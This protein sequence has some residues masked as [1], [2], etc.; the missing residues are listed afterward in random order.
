MTTEFSAP[1]PMQRAATPTAPRFRLHRA[2]IRNVWQY[3]E[4]E[5]AFGD[6]RLLLRGKNGAG[7]SKA[8]EML[9][10][11]LLDGDAR[12][13]DATGTGRTTLVWLML[14]GFEQTNRLGYLWVEFHLSAADGSDRYLTIGAAI[15]ASK[16]TK[17]AVPVFFVTPLRVGEDLHLV[18]AG[19]PLPVDKLKESI[20]AA[21][22]TERAVEHRARVARELFGITDTTRF[23]N[24]T[25]LLHRLRRPTVGDRIE[26][27]GLVSLLSETLPG[28][29]EEVVEKVARNLHDLDAVRDE[30][31]RLE[32]TD[33]A[34][35]A[36]LTGYRGYLTGVLRRASAG[37]SHELDVLTEWRRR[38]G[39][40]AKKTSDLR[41][42]EAEAD[43]RLTAVKE[44]QE[45]AQAELSA[46]HASDGYRSVQEL[47][48]RRDT[49]AALYT[50][51]AAT[52]TTVLTAH[53]AEQGAA[54]RLSDD[55]GRMAERLAE[56]A[57]DHRELMPEAERA[58]LPTGHLGE[59]VSPRCTDI[60][61]SQSVEVPDPD[62]ETQT[63]RHQR[64]IAADTAATARALDA[65][66]AQLEGGQSVAKSRSRSVKE[67]QRLS[68]HAREALAE[69]SLADAERERLETEM[70]EVAGRLEQARTQVVATS[71]GYAR[72]VTEW[73]ERVISALAPGCPA[74]D[75]VLDVI[76]C[77]TAP[78]A[79]FADRTLPAEI[80]TEAGQAAHLVL[81]P[82]GQ[83]LSDQR[84][85]AALAV[86]QLTVSYKDLEQQ[87]QA[88]E[89]RTD[90][91][92]PVPPHRAADRTAGSGAPFCQLVDFA[93]ELSATERAHLEAALEASGL[94]D[95]WISADGSVLDPGTLDTLLDPRAP[96]PAGPTLAAAL[97]PVVPAQTGVTAEL[98]DRVL[99]SIALAP[100]DE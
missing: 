3:D 12:A 2:G 86:N 66:R 97:R 48:E 33:A 89:Q 47:S 28:L 16:S 70:E 5:F 45:G 64:V 100:A 4:Q 51:A 84:D 49:V 74:L 8:L 34:L 11:Y 69:A 63:V 56:L 40:A 99:S 94:L 29:D 27:G 21:N 95:A 14:D 42:R 65:W 52:H 77:E 41:G 39:D 82:Y 46:L 57:T 38:T 22:V 83:M 50:A 17:K 92:P 1:V 72:E 54:G 13:L 6:G 9:L 96:A 59:A 73:T 93:E 53:G 62:G 24:L 55:V 88:W 79:P 25:Q 15:R 81:D 68:A 44:D 91:E 80:D 61:G 71:V 60:A 23:R 76:V 31:G 75:S 87:R 85:H 26:S 36:F 78:D 7:K 30:L 37:V 67:V 19:K 20:G 58:G 98:V 35:G 10:P 90:P 43:A 18:E 32:R